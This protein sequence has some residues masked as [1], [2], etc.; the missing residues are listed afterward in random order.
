MRIFGRLFEVVLF[1]W[2]V[3]IILL[4]LSIVTRHYGPATGS[5]LGLSLATG[6]IIRER[7]VMGL[8]WKTIFLRN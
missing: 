2:I 4:L 7:Y 3:G 5:F 8:S 1:T 6:L